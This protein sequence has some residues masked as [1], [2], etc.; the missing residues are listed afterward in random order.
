DVQSKSPETDRTSAWAY[1]ETR[2][3]PFVVRLKP[4]EERAIELPAGSNPSRALTIRLRASAHVPKNAS[5]LYWQASPALPKLD[6]A[7]RK[8][9]DAK[10]AEPS[11]ATRALLDK[12]DAA[13]ELLNEAS[14]ADYC[15]WDFD[16]AKGPSL[17][18]PHL[19][20]LRDLA[21]LALLK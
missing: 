14:H 5:V 20:P 2:E 17:Q 1:V 19:A 6:E 21:K 18:L 3:V 11:D 4:D 13:L 8:L 16:L 7:E 10:P 12:A 15:D 9:L